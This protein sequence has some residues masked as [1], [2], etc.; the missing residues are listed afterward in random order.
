MKLLF[1]ISTTQKL[2]V[3]SNFE[4]FNYFEFGAMWK[5][6]IEAGSNY[7]NMFYL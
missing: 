2:K 3:F 5:N 1:A 7:N 6:F 4:S